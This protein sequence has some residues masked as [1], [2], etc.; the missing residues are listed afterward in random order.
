MWCVRL[1]LS[2]LAPWLML[3][4]WRTWLC[5]VLATGVTVQQHALLCHLQDHPWMQSLH[6]H[7]CIDTI[8]NYCER[9]WCVVP[10]LHIWSK[11]YLLA[12]CSGEKQGVLF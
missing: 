1:R 6:L 12:A 7:R 3:S 10:L 4:V 11:Y 5:C 9:Y 8:C 2:L